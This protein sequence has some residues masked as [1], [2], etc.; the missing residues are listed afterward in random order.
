MANNPPSKYDSD[1]EAL[2]EARHW[3]SHINL[4]RHRGNSNVRSA[5][6]AARAAVEQAEAALLDVERMGGSDEQGSS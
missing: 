4:R 6:Q 2:S 5:V 1:F 3:L